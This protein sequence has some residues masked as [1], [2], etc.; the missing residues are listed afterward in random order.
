MLQALILNINLSVPLGVSSFD[1]KFCYSADN[2]RTN[3]TNLQMN[4]NNNQ[5]QIDLWNQQKE[6]DYEMWQKENEYNTPANQV[7][8][9]Q[10][11]GIN[12]ALAMSQISTGTATSS[13]GGQTPPQT[14]A[15][16]VE[17]NWQESLARIQNLALV[18]KTFSDINKQN[19]ET[20]ALR[21]Q[22][23]WIDA[24]NLAG[25]QE[26]GA[27]TKFNTANAL[28]RELENH[29]QSEVFDE[30]VGQFNQ[31]GLKLNYETLKE[32]AAAS[33]TENQSQHWKFVQEKLDPQ[34]LNNLKAAYAD[35][36]ASVALKY[37]NVEVNKANIEKIGHEVNNLVK[38]GTIL[39]KTASKMDQ[40]YYITDKT[41]G[42]TIQRIISES[43][44]SQFNNSFGLFLDYILKIPGFVSGLK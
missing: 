33:L 7:K 11:A 35:A 26:K 20:D 1:S 24:N 4:E 43:G 25:L 16:H 6:Y 14:T 44:R 15:G 37:S 30:R 13:A 5:T 40:D 36:F 22:N 34:Q 21:K 10:E 8:R 41:A 27:S 12:P 42:A 29:F 2:K 19:A 31:Q 38:Q 23:F 39:D 17:P 9:L 32:K 18:G 28:G 3:K